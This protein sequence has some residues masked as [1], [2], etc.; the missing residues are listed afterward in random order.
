MRWIFS[1]QTPWFPKLSCIPKYNSHTAIY[2][3]FIIII[4]KFTYRIN[5]KLF[6]TIE[7]INILGFHCNSENE[8]VQRYLF[9]I[10]L[11]ISYF[12]Q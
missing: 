9:S 12:K 5:S 7:L 6:I 3:I 1:T 8:K 10:Q 4:I 2:F 11:V